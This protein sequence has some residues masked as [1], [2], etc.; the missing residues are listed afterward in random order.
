MSALFNQ[1]NSAPGTSFAS[2]TGGSNITVQTI[3][4]VGNP[5]N[6]MNFNDLSGNVRVATGA[7]SFT[8][9]FNTETDTR[10]QMVPVGGVKLGFFNSS[11]SGGAYWAL[12]NN[13]PLGGFGVN[14]NT[15]SSLK[16]NVAAQTINMNALVSTLATA[17]PGCIS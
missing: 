6:Y 9:S 13:Q 10:I 16:A 3:Q 2:G 17:Y 12:G 11:G 14:L 7:S 1:T 5:N 15:I 8:V 4:A